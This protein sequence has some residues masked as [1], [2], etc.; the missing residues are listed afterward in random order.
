MIGRALR[1]LIFRGCVALALLVLHSFASIENA[2]AATGQLTAQITVNGIPASIETE[3]DLNLRV[4]KEAGKTSYS[5]SDIRTI[6]VGHLKVTQNPGAYTRVTV[7]TS[8]TLTAGNGTS[9]AELTFSCRKDSTGYL[10][11]VTSG[12]DCATPSTTSTG[13]VFV[14]IFPSSVVFSTAN[15]IGA[16]TGT[17]QVTVDYW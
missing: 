2:G 17:I 14:D 10:E 3:Q 15:T 9:T 4:A 7:P 6:T 1:A 5:A 12:V 11:T 16:Y 13:E 8:V